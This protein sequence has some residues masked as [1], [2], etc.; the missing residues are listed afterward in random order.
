MRDGD[1]VQALMREIQTLDVPEAHE[2]GVYEANLNAIIAHVDTAVLGHPRIAEMLGGNPPEIVKVNHRNHAG[3]M[4][5]ILRAGTLEDLPATAVWAYRAYI[6]RGIHPDYWTVHLPQWEA[7]FASLGLA[8]SLP[9]TAAVYRWLAD[10]H[11]ELLARSREPAPTPVFSS[12]VSQAFA[13]RLVAL[14]L[15]GSLAIVEETLEAGTSVTTV[16]T[17]LIDPALQLV[18]ARW[19]DG[20]LTSAHEHR[21]TAIATRLIGSMLARI[22]IGTARGAGALVTSAESEYHDVG[23]LSMALYFEAAG[24]DVSYLGAN[25]PNR[26]VVELAAEFDPEIV[27]VSVTIPGH[28]PSVRRLVADLRQ[29]TDARIVVGGGLLRRIPSLA[30]NVDADLV[31]HDP[32]EALQ[33]AE[34]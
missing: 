22:D 18:G 1:E 20:V 2:L 29:V 5:E 19:E 31:T 34:R 10:H 12:E 15:Q 7:A 16:L 9:R 28:L 6:S 27:A 32:V 25:A 4:A 30:G 14:D 17:E 11:D 3:F 8:G 26:D 21:A 13:D 24:W 33:W 23:A